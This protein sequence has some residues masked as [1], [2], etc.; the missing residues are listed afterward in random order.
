MI[1]FGRIT[2]QGQS[3]YIKSMK[4]IESFRL[5]YSINESNHGIIRDAVTENTAIGKAAL[6][7]A[8]LYFWGLVKIN[9]L[10]RVLK[11][12]LNNN[13]FNQLGIFE[14]HELELCLGYELLSAFLNEKVTS[15]SNILL[16][17]N[18]LRK[19]KEE[20]KLITEDVWCYIPPPTGFFSVIENII[21][22]K[23]ICKLN[24]KIFKLD[25]NHNWWKYPV[26][27]MEFM[28]SKLTLE[29]NLSNKTDYY[30]T[31]DVL[32]AAL[33]KIPPE[34]YE[35][36]AEFKISE[37]KKIKASL[38]NFHASLKRTTL[39][40]Q[41]GCVCYIRGGDKT[42]LE[43]ITTPKE[44]LHHDI[45]QVASLD[46]PV[47]LLSDDFSLAENIKNELKSNNIHNI[48]KKIF[49]GYF[50]QSNSIDDV[51]AILENYIILSNTRFNLSCPSSN[52]VNSAN[53]SNE[54]LSREFK[55]RS[56]PGSKYLFL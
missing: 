40:M 46:I 50:L 55:F 4:F 39:G 19:I 26:P 38:Q 16:P 45:N 2:Y 53:W 43:T 27:F 44:L 48:T 49:N 56:Y 31:W 25:M 20:E 32:R 10:I 52:L 33:T 12:R 22:A 54:N 28:D 5:I 21:Y 51:Y 42:L 36:L 47:Y 13:N 14:R 6:I 17:T 8:R 7:Y 18:D 15:I 37:Y 23:F 11:D 24:N 35:E 29:Y 30:L 34:Q 9:D 1:Q 3:D 41:D